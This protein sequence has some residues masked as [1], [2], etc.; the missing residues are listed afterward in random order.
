MEIKKVYC[1]FQKISVSSLPVC[2]S[3]VLPIPAIILYFLISSKVKING[4]VPKSCSHPPT[5]RKLR[6]HEI[7][8]VIKSCMTA[9]LVPKGSNEDAG[10]VLRTE[11]GGGGAQQL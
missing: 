4:K 8:T 5:I 11:V 1:S 7:T 3:E 10:C 6:S 9:A 2:L